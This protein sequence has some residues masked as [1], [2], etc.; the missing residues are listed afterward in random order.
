MANP[1]EEV[2]IHRLEDS[3]TFSV[4]WVALMTYI[5]SF[6]TLEEEAVDLEDKEVLVV[7]EWEE[8]FQVVDSEAAVLMGLCDVKL[9]RNNCN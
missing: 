9:I 1:E 4:K 8:D 7:A 5:H 6:L 2:L 3:Q